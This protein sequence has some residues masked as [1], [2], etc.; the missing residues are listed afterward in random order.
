MKF[1]HSSDNTKAITEL[2]EAEES[3]K[4]AVAFW[5]GLAA[6]LKWH[7]PKKVQV[8]C[9]L[10]SGATNP[11]AI[12]QLKKMGVKVKTNKHLH[13][14]VYLAETQAIVSSANASANG[15]SLEGRE[16]ESWL[17][18][19]VQIEDAHT[20]EEIR[21]WFE[22]QWNCAINV[23]KP[24]LNE[25]QIKWERKRNQREFY[26][27]DKETLLSLL[28]APEGRLDERR[29]YIAIYRVE[30][31]SE[32]ALEKFEEVEKSH[33]T[34]KILGFYEDWSS[35]PR[36]AE[37]ISVYYPREE[38]SKPVYEFYYVPSGQVGIHDF[39]YRDG[40]SSDILVC[41]KLN[42]IRDFK[43]SPQDK[44]LITSKLQNLWESQEPDE[45]EAVYLSLLDAKDILFPQ[46]SR[47]KK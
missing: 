38:G 7:N 45:N 37:L 11:D 39:E 30:E 24:M 9:N 20:L 22:A 17:E 12:R 32:E 25:A 23:T 44:R 34:D 26:K 14:K 5:G 29:I 21:R 43:L 16:L 27:T 8:I 3:I 1:L 36:D 28:S 18:A 40:G 46:K 35:L 31:A 10:E 2:L 6:E 41:E 13:A 19:S 15:L 4:C 33:G 42:S 47:K